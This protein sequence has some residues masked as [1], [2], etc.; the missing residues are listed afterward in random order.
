MVD[1]PPS[2]QGF[3][4]LMRFGLGARGESDLAAA[5][6]DPRGFLKAELGLPGIALLDPRADRGTTAALLQTLFADQQRIKM[7][8]D[9]KP[10]PAAAGTDM[11]AP[12]IP[13]AKPV[14]MQPNIEQQVFR[15]EALAR[16][17]RAAEAPSGLVE[18]LVAFWSNHFCVSA[19]KGQFVRMTCGAFERE[20]I[21]PHVLGRFADML[22]AVEQHPTMLH[23]LDNQQSIGPTSK[24][25]QNRK[26]GL[27]ENLAREIMELHTMGVGSGYAQADVAALARMLTGWTVAGQEGRL[28][29]PGTFAFNAN[30]H[31]PGVHSLLGKAY[32]ATGAGQGETALADIA[33]H[34]ATAKFIAAKFAGHFV[35]DAPPPALVAQLAKVFASSDGDLRAMTLALLDSD[36]AWTLPLAKLRSPYEFL[37]AS[38]RSANRAPDSADPILNGLNLMGMPLWQPPGPNG[39]PDSVAAWAS[40]EGMKQRLDVAAQIAARWKDIPKPGDLLQAL[41]GD[42]ASSETRQAIARAE[43][44][45]QGMALL[46]MSPEFQRR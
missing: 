35:A 1:S 4:A 19:R 11:A 42:A 29:E 41:A 24:A 31:E 16:F 10:A 26:H 34:A 18:R 12:A 13:A 27:N 23:Y 22:R 38:A 30:A 36:E 45:Q 46:L 20:A 32:P 44:R 8:R 39:W 6:S 17:Q 7:E 37:I 15:A 14:A 33:R 9:S 21:R 43:S 40:P 25:G 28:G 5:Q 2:H 3:V